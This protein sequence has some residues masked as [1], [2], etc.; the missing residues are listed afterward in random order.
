MK[1]TNISYV[2]AHLSEVLRRVKAGETVTVVE[3]RKPVA[4][5]KPIAGRGD[6]SDGWIEDLVRRGVIGASAEKLDVRAFLSMPKPKWKGGRS[7]A[8]HIRAD[9][10]DRV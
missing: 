10:E 1:V 9:R 3:R 6:S 7:L 8:E 5:I 4:T 2:K